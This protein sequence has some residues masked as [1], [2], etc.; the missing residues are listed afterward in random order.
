MPGVVWV[1]VGAKVAAARTKINAILSN[2][3]GF[4]PGPPCAQPLLSRCATVAPEE[5]IMVLTPFFDELQP[6]PPLNQARQLPSKR[7]VGVWL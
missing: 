5:S 1:P 6:L 2:F 4:S 7:T 3:G